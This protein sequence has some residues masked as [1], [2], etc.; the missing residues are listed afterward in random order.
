MKFSVVFLAA[1]AMAAVAPE[2]VESG[3]AALT[4]EAPAVTDAA[5]SV[6]K[7]WTTS[8]VYEYNVITV[9]DCAETVTDCP[10]DATKVVT[11]TVAVST[12]VC[13]VDDD[14]DTPSTLV[15]TSTGGSSPEEPEPTG[16]PEESSTEGSS[17]EQPEPT[18]YPEE[19][20]PQ[21]PATKVKTITTSYTTVIP[22]VIVETYVEDC[23]APT[24]GVD[25]P[26]PTGGVPGGNTTTPQPSQPVTAG[27]AS[28]AGSIFFAAA[29]GI[30]AYAF[31]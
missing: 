7:K 28:M 4:T 13:P 17:P 15:P 20:V 1:G 21:C 24:G 18:G 14:D 9:T 8:T 31:A 6:A 26:V 29:A 22:T 19:P 5:T 23:P 12:T 11:E 25:T 10:G 2:P 16:Y 3:S 30:A 27:A